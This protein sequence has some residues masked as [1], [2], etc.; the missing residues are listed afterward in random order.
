MIIANVSLCTCCV[1]L[2]CVVCRIGRRTNDIDW[3]DSRHL[4]YERFD[5]S[6]KTHEVIIVHPLDDCCTV[7]SL[8]FKIIK[9]L[10]FNKSLLL[11]KFYMAFN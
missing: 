3:F 4:I 11:K 10:K 8:V 7:D 9:N 5:R 1:L 2:V 6:Y